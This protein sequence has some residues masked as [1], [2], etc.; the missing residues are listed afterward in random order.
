M[1]TAPFAKGVSLRLDRP[2]QM[3]ILGGWL[4]ALIRKNISG[5]EQVHSARFKLESIVRHHKVQLDDC[6]RLELA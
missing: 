5:K 4:Y 3:A 2:K 1:P 6:L